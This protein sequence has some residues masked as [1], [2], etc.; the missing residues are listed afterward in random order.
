MEQGEERL[1]LSIID[2]INALVLGK[3]T[4]SYDV[5][6][7]A[8]ILG[9]MDSAR[10]YS[11]NMRTAKNFRHNIDLITHCMGLRSVEGFV[12]EFGVAS[13]RT[14]NHI[15]SC[16]DQKVYG[17]DVFA[18]LPETWRTGF[19]SGMFAQDLPKVSGNVELL[20]GL[21]ENTLPEFVRQSGDAKVSF[22]HVDCDLYSST[23]TIFEHLGR[24]IVPGTVIVFDEY[25]N[26]PGWQ[27]HEFKAFR[28]FCREFSVRYRY[29]SLVSIH[30]QVCAV[31]ESVG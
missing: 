9:A 11:E 19:E 1:V 4:D 6:T 26:Y 12:L 2:N 25:F 8:N 21:F 24:K 31:I 29:D 16:T 22:L 5:L 14:V 23:K 13:G 15:A 27:H 30:Q 28:E 20:V 18:G 3:Y 17:F 10:Y 7:F